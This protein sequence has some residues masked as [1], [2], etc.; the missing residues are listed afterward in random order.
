[1]IKPYRISSSSQA[2]SYRWILLLALLTSLGPLSID[3][4]LPAL[5]VMADAFQVSTQQ[6]ANSLPA[7]FLGLAVG[8]LI[9]GPLSDRLG[10][11]I[12][13]YFGLS[14]YVVASVL[15]LFTY[16]E[17]SLMGARVLQALGGCVG[18][19]TARAAIR[20]RFEGEQA[21]QAFASMMIVMTIAPIVAPSLGALL[22][23]FFEWQMLFVVLAMIGVICLLCTHFFFDETLVVERRLIL[24]VRQVLNLYLMIL[25]D[26]SFVIPMLVG[27]FSGGML[28]VYISA[29]AAVFM[30]GFA[31][32]QQQFGW[33]FGLNALGIVAFSSLNKPLAKKLNVYQRLALG[34]GVQ[35]FG[36][37][38]LVIMV[39]GA[40]ANL[41]WV[42]LGVFFAEAGIGLTGPNTMA[43]AMS[44]QG[45]RA[46][47]ASAIMGSM[48]FACG[49]LGGLLLNV[50]PWSVLSNM[51][52]AMLCFMM[53]SF[54]FMLRLYL[55]YRHA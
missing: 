54:V 33:L 36:V 12:P 19:V 17:W 35:I 11:K 10:R 39:S 4:Y 40:S 18:V 20:D 43:I 2:Y 32:S 44:Q 48:Q 5:P 29:S 55:K 46:G 49:L 45:Q 14:L 52:F 3:L 28:F 9:Y 23:H 16:N 8:Q 15:C 42:A 26:P 6:V 24:S 50:L 31:L 25:K 34:H 7:Y 27:C 22:L 41:F 13:L 30:D 53:V 37:L 1:M 38:I 21:A 47:T 51:A